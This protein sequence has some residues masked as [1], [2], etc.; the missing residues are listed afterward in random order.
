MPEKKSR[1]FDYLPL[2]IRLETLGGIATPLVLRGTPLPTKRSDTFSTASD[3]QS[4]VELSLFIGESPL[5]QNNTPIGKFKLDHIPPGARGVPQVFVEFSVDKSC[6]IVAKANVK[7]TAISTEQALSP[8]EDLSD[9]FISKALAAAESTQENDEAEI[10]RIEAVSRANN[11]IVQ[12]EERLKSGSNN[13]LSEA[14]AALGLALASEDSD[15]I[16]EKSDLLDSAL[17]PSLDNIFSSIDFDS[18]F[19]KSSATMRKKDGQ[20]KKR[21]S[22]PKQEITSATKNLILGKI[23]GGGSFTLDPQLCFVLMPFADKL[24][25]IYDDHIIPAVENAGLRCERADDIRGINL[26]TWDIWERINRARFLIAELTDRNPNVFYELG[27]AHALSKD[28]I[29][30][31]QSME[32]VPF[33]L[34]SLRCITYEFTPR[35]IQKL[36]KGLSATISAIMKSG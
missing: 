18:F 28:V 15:N 6:A 13:K 25:P 4:S 27:L 22:I 32:F 20:Q 35:G 31:T 5:A 10:L 9:V 12:A 11:L 33:D 21:A 34:K 29:L 14:V 17:K 16:R 8:P 26:I 1:T 30:I 7:G 24:K 3:N 23:F 36:E 19:S 2:T